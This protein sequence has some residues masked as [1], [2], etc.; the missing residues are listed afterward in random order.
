V[1]TSLVMKYL[2]VLVSYSF[3]TLSVAIIEFTWMTSLFRKVIK[4]QAVPN[5]QTFV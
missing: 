4:Q 3:K 1:P 5:K 2:I